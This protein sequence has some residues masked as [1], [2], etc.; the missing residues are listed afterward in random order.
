MDREKAIRITRQ[1]VIKYDP[2]HMILTRNLDHCHLERLKMT[3]MVIV[4]N[5]CS[6]TSTLFY[7][8][9]TFSQTIN[10]STISLYWIPG[11]FFTEVL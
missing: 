6:K 1:M 10:S 9:R 5:C 7:I 4:F 3:P 11:Y 8:R 2:Q